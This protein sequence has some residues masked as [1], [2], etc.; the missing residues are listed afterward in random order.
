MNELV[1]YLTENCRRGTTCD[2][3]C[4]PA[5]RLKRKAS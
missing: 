4:A 5:P 3:A 2:I 1:A